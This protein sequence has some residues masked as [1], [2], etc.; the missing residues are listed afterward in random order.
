MAQ[1]RPGPVPRPRLD[2]DGLLRFG[3]RWVAIPDTQ[4]PVVSLL[5]DRCR[6]LVRPEEISAAYRAGGGHVSPSRTYV[7]VARLRARLRPLGLELY[8]IRGRGVVL[9]VADAA[10]ELEPELDPAPEPPA[11]TDPQ[12]GPCSNS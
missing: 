8:A 2:A 1:L 9:D 10:V 4:V 3:G 6:E 7:L 5:V 11:R 12:E